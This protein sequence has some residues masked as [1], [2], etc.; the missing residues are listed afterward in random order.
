[1]DQDIKSSK[2]ID[3]S[4]EIRDDFY[5]VLYGRRD[6]RGQFLP[7]EIP[8]E[9]LT[10]ILH[11]AHHAPSVG[12]SQPWNFILI[13]DNEQRKRIYDAFVE[14]NDEAAQMFEGGRRSHYQSLKLQGILDTPLN[15]CITCDRERG[16]PVVLGKTHQAEMDLYSTVCAV[17]NFWLAARAENIGVGWVSIIQKEKLT[18]LLELPEN[19]V[20]VAYLCVGYV[21][22]FLKKPELELAQ[23]EKRLQLEE[24]IYAD[25]WGRKK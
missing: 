21:S 14:A 10:N 23:W 8:D 24:L 17:Q 2:H 20:P 11:A 4:Q 5:Q 7:D 25:K 19:I 1:M 3:I 13:R 6:V 22:E 12:L 16:G 18:E 9:V 15:V